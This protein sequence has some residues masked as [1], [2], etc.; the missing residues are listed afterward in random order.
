MATIELG[1]LQSSRRRVVVE[2][3]A[4]LRT[5]RPKRQQGIHRRGMP[6][7]PRSRGSRP[8]RA[9]TTRR[10]RRQ[11]PD[12]CGRNSRRRGHPPHPGA[13]PGRSP[14]TPRRLGRAGA[15]QA[16]TANSD[17]AVGGAE[18]ETARR[19]ETPRRCQKAAQA[20]GRLLSGTFDRAK[21]RDR[22]AAVGMATRDEFLRQRAYPVQFDRSVAELL[23]RDVDVRRQA[24]RFIVGVAVDV[25]ASIGYRP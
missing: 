5:R 21:A 16:E 14:G 4:R 23:H 12:R 20:A 10:S 11:S 19:Q 17:E 24:G 15:R 13:Q 25:D 3:H 1:G 7:R 2:L 18:G 22:G 9:A 6:S 8:G